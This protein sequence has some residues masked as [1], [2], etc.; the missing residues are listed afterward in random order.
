MYDLYIVYDRNSYNGATY[1]RVDGFYNTVD[2][3]KAALE[4]LE[5]LDLPLVE[6]TYRPVSVRI[7]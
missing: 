7:V 2:E 6:W 4:R 1:S 3:V 5:A